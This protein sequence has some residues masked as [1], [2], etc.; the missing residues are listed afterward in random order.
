MNQ[1]SNAQRPATSRPVPLPPPVPVRTNAARP[2]H[3]APV[4]KQSNNNFRRQSGR[5]NNKHSG[6]RGSH[7]GVHFG[8]PR[9][10]HLPSA[11]QPPRNPDA[12]YLLPLGG[13]EE[14]GRNCS[15]VEYKND[16]VIIDLGLMFPTENMHGIDYIIP[17]ISPLYGKEKKIKGV[18]VTHAH[19]DHFGGVPHLLPKLGN[20][21]IYG[22]EFTMRLVEKRQADFPNY[23]KP[24]VN[25]VKPNQKFRLGELELETFHVN[26][27]VPNA[28]GVVVSSPAGSIAFTGDF[29]FDSNPVND[30]PADE[31]HIKQLGEK[32]IS[33]L[34]T[35]STGAER[36]GHSI[37][38][39]VI[40]TNLEKIFEAHSNQRII[41][42]TF[43]SMIDRLQQMIAI[44]E[45]YGRKIA[46]DGYS[47]KTNV[48]IAR[49]IGFMKLHKES[50]ITPE[51]SNKLPPGKVLVL[52]TGAQGEDNAVLMRI[53]NKEHRSLELQAG[54]VVIFSSSV[55]PGNEASVQMV[56]DQIYK[57]G[58]EVYHYKMMDIHSGGHGHRDDLLHMIELTQ[59][60]YLIP[61]HGYFSFRAEHAKLA[62]NHGYPRDHILLPSNGEVIE[63]TP[64][65]V[66]LTGEKYEIDHIMVD[67]LGV[68]D[69]GNVVL[70]DRQMLASDGMVVVIATVDGRTGDVVG[71][72]DIISRGFIYIKEQQQLIKDT[73]QQIRNIISK[74]SGQNH[75]GEPN[76]THLKAT[77]R[78]SVG[79]FLFQKTERRPMILPVIVEV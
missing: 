19:Y 11:K 23:A 4:L 24:K 26:H 36:E 45:R 3:Q 37:S 77:L 43:S 8:P 70:R 66:R 71:E 48:E 33:V 9:S 15:A 47:M 25:V 53:V 2:R 14:I 72:P 27:S 38:E 20:P 42:A 79:Q 58:A 10:R 6:R 51:E 59:P 21:P 64:D 1:P 49:E 78:D 18:I 67:G 76:W 73:R 46:I 28:F 61:A 12:M 50:L 60:K 34:Y 22:S 65:K 44:A 41:A 31:V 52:C 74:Q 75:G 29:K 55:I 40:E 7:A 39:S 5:P 63:I 57:Q 54:D 30:L 35:D 13:L 32:G 17:D 69:V 68:G 16:I 62:V 56:K